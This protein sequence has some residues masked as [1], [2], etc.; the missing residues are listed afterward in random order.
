MPIGQVA[1]V[2]R[3][4]ALMAV[5]L[6]PAGQGVGAQ[7]EEGVGQYEPA[8]Q[9]SAVAEPIGHTLPAEVQDMHGNPLPRAPTT[10]PPLV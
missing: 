6:V 4:V 8:E 7:A 5:E 3:E 10:E 1:Q 9:A 2:A